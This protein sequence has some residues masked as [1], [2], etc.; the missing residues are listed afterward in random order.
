MRHEGISN[1]RTGLAW[2]TAFRALSSGRRRRVLTLLAEEGETTI[3]D[4]ARRLVGGD[5]SG[6]SDQR[7]RETLEI[8][9]HHA[10]LPALQTAGLVEWDRADGTVSLASGIG[11]LPLFTPPSEPPAARRGA[12]TPARCSDVE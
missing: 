2:D 10:H 6:D 9:L 11:R 4:I 3:S 5:A 8:A 1:G 7:E 12:V